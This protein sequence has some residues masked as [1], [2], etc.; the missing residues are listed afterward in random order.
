MRKM[1]LAMALLAGCAGVPKGQFKFDPNSRVSNS[2]PDPQ[3]AS[4]TC[5]ER[6]GDS[7]DYHLDQTGLGVFAVMRL[8]ERQWADRHIACMHQQGWAWVEG[9]PPTESSRERL[10]DVAAPGEQ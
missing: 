5:I 9:P 6:H 10:D 8:Q 7:P 3:L 4:A 2:E 1:I